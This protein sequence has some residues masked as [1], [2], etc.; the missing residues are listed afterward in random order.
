MDR[1][2]RRFSYASLWVFAIAFGW[3]EGTAVVYLREIYAREVMLNAGADTIGSVPISL[4]ALPGSLVTVEMLREAC[5]IALLAAVAWLAGRQVADRIGA[6]LLSFGLW[7]LTYYAAL[8]T[9]AAWPDRLTTWD[10]LFLIP[11]PWVAPI[12]APMIVAV[13]FA[14]SGTYLFWTA[15]RDRRYRWTDGAVLT[16]AALLTV[17]AFLF[18]SKAVIGHRIPNSF[19]VWLFSSGV[20]LGG[21]WF[22]RVERASV[23]PPTRPW[24]GVN[25]R[26]LLP[27]S[28]PRNELSA[29]TEYRERRRRLDGLLQDARDV[30][31][32]FNRLGHALSTHPDR[33]IVGIPDVQPKNLNEWEVLSSCP[34]P[35]VEQV[36]TLT[37]KIRQLCA[38]VDG[39]EERLILTGHANVVDQ[40]D[41]Y[42]H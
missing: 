9:I 19:P 16:A 33:V 27:E 2:A 40:R 17:A 11:S 32:Q 21:G 3:I 41:E 31:E 42:F 28:E 23:R 26:T 22:V 14:G 38:E 35:S 24:I 7:D 4:I 12:W 15:D 37:A 34:L 5:T 39:L 36:A 6:F 13:L 20:L 29:M 25:M 8:R 1:D 10:I 18:G 30:G